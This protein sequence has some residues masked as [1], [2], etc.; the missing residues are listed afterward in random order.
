MGRYICWLRN[1]QARLLRSGALLL[2]QLLRVEVQLL[3]LQDVA[4]ASPALAWSRGDAG[5]QTAAGEGVIE[6]GVESARLLSLLQLS[7]DALRLAGQLLL[8]LLPRLLESHLDA[9]VLLV[10]GAKGRGVDLDDG[11]LDQRLRADQL[12]M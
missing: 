7:E 12:V 11:V 3:A 10:P 4:I 9:V 2:L 8:H 1:S 5:Q 6:G